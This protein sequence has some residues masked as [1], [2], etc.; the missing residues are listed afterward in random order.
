MFTIPVSRVRTDGGTQSR[1]GL[2]ADTVNDYVEAIER[3]DQ[4]PS[5]VVFFDGKEYWLADGFHRHAAY[6][7]AGHEDISADV[8]QGSR[9]DAILYSVGANAS[10]GLR[11][12]NDDKR[13]AVMVLLNDAEWSKWSDRDIAR[14]AGVSHPFVAKMRGELSGNGF[15][16]E[17]R[18]VNRN[19][20]IYQ[21]KTAKIG[22]SRP[23]KPD[24]SKDDAQTSAS[25]VVH[26]EPT[27]SIRPVDDDTGSHKELRGLTRD[28]L[29]DEIIG[30]REENAELRAENTK[31]RHEI[32]SLTNKVSEL[33]STNQGAIISKLQKQ[34][35]AAKYSRD[36]AKLATKRMEFRLNQTLKEQRGVDAA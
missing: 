31:Q 30:L 28:G 29:E 1:A 15:Q 24:A 7:A 20:T 22:K 8:Q 9:R 4:F 14:Q 21:Q 17:T 25:E 13:R 2:N 12:T 36:E 34:L 19:G 18:T 23:D 35:Q 3:G 26:D 33:S 10:H 5:I 16:I 11:R 6:V 27:S 32:E